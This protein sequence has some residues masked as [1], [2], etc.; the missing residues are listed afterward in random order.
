MYLSVFSHPFLLLTGLNC[1]NLQRA[2]TPEIFDGICSKVNQ[3]S[4]HHPQSD[5]VSSP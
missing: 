4:T 5:K 1:P 3:E 2:I